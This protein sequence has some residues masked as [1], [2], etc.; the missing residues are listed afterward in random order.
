MKFMAAFLVCG[1][2]LWN[3]ALAIGQNPI[4]FKAMMQSP[5]VQQTV[6][7]MPNRGSPQDLSASATAT[8]TGALTPKGKAMMIG[9]IVLVAAGA[10]VIAA[11]AAFGSTMGTKGAE[12]KTAVGYVGGFSAVGTGVTLIVFGARHRSK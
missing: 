9:G 3:S 2:I 4:P 8:H 5:G 1:A 7:P 6:A 11:D 12:G 10:V